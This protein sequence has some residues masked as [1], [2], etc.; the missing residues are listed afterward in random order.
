[1]RIRT[2]KD[3][4][5][6]IRDFR[7]QRKLTQAALA[8]LIGVSRRWVVQVEQAKTSPDLR[9]VLRALRALG[10]E[11]HVRPRHV[12]PEALEVTRIV[13]REKRRKQ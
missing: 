3:L 11:M 7:K 10:A 6:L 4:G 2:R 9:T 12:S 5:L 1:M 13:D 8:E